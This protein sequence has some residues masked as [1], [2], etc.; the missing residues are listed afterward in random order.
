MFFFEKMLK[1]VASGN[2][3]KSNGKIDTFSIGN[4]R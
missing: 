2:K 3:S 1:I 4:E